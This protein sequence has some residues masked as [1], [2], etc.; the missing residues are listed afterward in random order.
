MAKKRRA[1]I[2]QLLAAGKL[3][4]EML[5][6]KGV[7]AKDSVLDKIITSK[8]APKLPGVPVYLPQSW[9]IR[10]S[11]RM[12]YDLLLIWKDECKGNNK[13]AENITEFFKFIVAELRKQEEK[14]EAE[15]AA[16]PKMMRTM[17]NVPVLKD[18]FSPMR[19]KDTA[20]AIHRFFIDS[21]AVAIV[22]KNNH[23][24]SEYA[25]WFLDW[26][27][28]LYALWVKPEKPVIKKI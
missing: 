5:I 9:T 17:K 4:K 26:T 15:M 1:P 25:N 19:K 13:R 7:I 21:F 23:T 12:L 18:I 20:K 28:E 14:Y 24:T 16:M 3:A 2:Q 6:Q 8:D 22:L 11:Q 27:Q 10:A